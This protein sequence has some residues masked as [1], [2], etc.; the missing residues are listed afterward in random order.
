MKEKTSERLECK[1]QA[2]Y[3]WLE[4][5][6]QLD[7]YLWNHHSRDGE[8]IL[9]EDLAMIHFESNLIVENAYWSRP[10]N[11]LSSFPGLANRYD[12]QKDEIYKECRK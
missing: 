8:N 2:F 6:N 4:G 3:N 1:L 7:N 12:Q 9:R 10:R 11:M 5:E